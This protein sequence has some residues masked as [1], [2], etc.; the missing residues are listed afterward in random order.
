LYSG[1]VAF[2]MPKMIHAAHFASTLAWSFFWLYWIVSSVRTK[3]S[4]RREPVGI[5]ALRVGLV[6]F[7][8]NVWLAGGP[9]LRTRFVPPS[10][11]AA[12]GGLALVLGGLAF[13]V[14]ARLHLGSNWS[15][16]VTLKEGHELV[17]SGPYA[18]VRHPIYTGLL[19]ALLGSAVMNGE[20]RSLAAVALLAVALLVKMRLEER[21]MVE[22]FGEEYRQYRR[23]V[24]ALVPFV[25]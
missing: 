6:V 8:A 16:T 22:R 19:A 23:E 18:L 15:A 11:A 9:V 1:A 12:L 13:A 25:A 14:W 17:R 5:F 20:M 10:S 21:W 4:Q 24:K 7:A 3:A 2:T